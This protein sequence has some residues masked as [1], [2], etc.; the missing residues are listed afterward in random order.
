[1]RKDMAKVIVERPRR[2]GNWAHKK[3]RAPQ[4]ADLLVS[5]EGMR[6]PHVRHWGGKELNENLAPLRRF[7]M[8][9][10]GQPWDK[11]YGE[12]SE[13]LKITSA[14]QQ[15]V[16]DHVQDFVI[17]RVRVDDEGQ[18]WGVSYGAPYRIGEGWWRRELYVDP[19][20]GI[21]KRTPDQPKLM[22]YKE[23]REAH[24]AE[25]HRAVD[26]TH[27]LRKHKGVW[28]WCEVARMQRGEWVNYVDPTTGLPR[29][30]WVGKTYWDVLLNDYVSMEQHNS[31]RGTYVVHK[32]QL[33]HKELKAHG[34]QND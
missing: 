25:T 26:D 30:R 12:I 29:N 21:L 31:W 8:S 18:L 7:L 19:R 20:D 23:R 9:R 15:H 22:S 32:R 6:A 14:V 13:N 34:V 4:D 10:V 17:T 28:Y 2:G 5:K 3:G 27:E 16:R 33:N 1:M 11:V 24:F